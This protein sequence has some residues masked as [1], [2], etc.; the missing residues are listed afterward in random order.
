MGGFCD[1]RKAVE[2]RSGA[3]PGSLASNIGE[4]YIA[5]EVRQ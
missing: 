4:K 1:A 2:E 3:M 5:V